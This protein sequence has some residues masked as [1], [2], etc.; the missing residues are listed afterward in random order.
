MDPSTIIADGM[1]VTIHGMNQTF[2]ANNAVL[3]QGQ[4]AYAENA[5]YSYLIGKDQMSSVQALGFRTA[6][7]AGSGRERQLDSTGGA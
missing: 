6:T 7:E 5:R 2:A 3:M 4:S 1:G